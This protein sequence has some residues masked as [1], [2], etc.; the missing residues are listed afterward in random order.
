MEYSIFPKFRFQLRCNPYNF[1]DIRDMRIDIYNISLYKK[2]IEVFIS[3]DSAS[4]LH[5]RKPTPQQ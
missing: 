2:K 4:L 1:R 5:K 3:E